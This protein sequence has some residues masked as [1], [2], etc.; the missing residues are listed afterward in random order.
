MK[1]NKKRSMKHILQ[2]RFVA[3]ATLSA[4]VL[5]CMIDGIVLLRSYGQIVEKADYLIRTIRTDPYSEDVGD[6]H[7]FTVFLSKKEQRVD[8]S[9]TSFMRE[10][11][12]VALGRRAL[13]AEKQ[14][15]F[16]DGYRFSVERQENG[17]SILFLSRRLPLETFQET[18][19]LLIAVS[20]T[21]LGLTAAV[22]ALLS[23]K[24][25]APIVEA[26]EKQKE[27][28]T[29]ASH[30]L[31]TPVAVILGD[32]QLLQMEHEGNEWLMDIEKQAK[33]LVEMT[34]S[35]VTLARCDEGLRQ[36][37]FIEFPLSDVAQDAADS[38]QS[39]AA[40]RELSF[41][42]DISPNIGYFGDEKALREMLTI[43]LDNAC[44]YCPGGG[45]VR[46]TLKKKRRGIVIVVENTAENIHEEE[47]SRFTE[48]FYRG[49]TAGS[50]SGSGLGLSIAQSVARRHRGRL[51]ITAPTGQ[52][53]RVW[54]V[55]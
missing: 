4:A 20:L 36:D 47:L 23:G 22:L 40:S 30:A 34:R 8:L 11:A 39:I 2:L 48:R 53:I 7:Y 24:V 32:A 54:V 46:F 43:L 27:F 31:K 44:R 33:R 21:G 50:T 25:V 29:S 12:A 6:A 15:G 26:G 38:F 28:I 49:S 37:S 1:R 9:H 18:Q 10:D 5:L 14:Q 17:A 52:S 45:S 19:R 35:L 13:K 16:L 3:M 42:V 51:S 55:L 41:E